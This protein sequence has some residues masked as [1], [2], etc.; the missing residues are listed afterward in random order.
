MKQMHI[1]DCEKEI[2]REGEEWTGVR[3]SE[4]DSGHHAIYSSEKEK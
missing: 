2:Y 1:Q 3:E 4:G